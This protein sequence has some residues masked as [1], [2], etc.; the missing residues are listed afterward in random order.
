MKN[1]MIIYGQLLTDIKDRIRQGQVRAH[2]SANA[3][4]LATYWDIG[5]MIH[6]GQRA[7]GWGKGFL[8]RL[9]KDLKNELAEVKGFSER[10]LQFMIQFYL[11]YSDVFSITKLSVS[12][13]E[14]RTE[15]ITKRTVSEFN[16]TNLKERNVQ[17]QLLLLTG[18]A[19][20]ITLIQKVK[21]LKVR[22]WY[23]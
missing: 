2:L 15:S 6:M 8:T 14:E 19:H 20:H 13:L 5:K 10:N 17:N 11:E 12:Q 3:E 16:H 1:D 4:L 9:A 21:D 22:Y 23:M 18:W 7:E